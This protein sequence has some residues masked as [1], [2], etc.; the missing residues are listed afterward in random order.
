MW[1]LWISSCLKTS[2]KDRTD[3]GLDTLV[4]L[5]LLTALTALGRNLG[6]TELVSMSLELTLLT[7]N[8]SN[9]VQGPIYMDLTP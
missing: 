4:Q 3:Y 8:Q 6:A 1:Q 2:C 7:R 5:F 9:F